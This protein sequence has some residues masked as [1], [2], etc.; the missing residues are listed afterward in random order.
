MGLP[1]FSLAPVPD[2]RSEVPLQL[3]P[4]FSVRPGPSW[5]SCLRLPLQLTFAFDAVESHMRPSSCSSA[6]SS[7]DHA[8]CNTAVVVWP[9]LGLACRLF[10]NCP[11]VMVMFFTLQTVFCFPRRISLGT[12]LRQ[13]M[14]WN[15]ISFVETRPAD[16]LVTF[17]CGTTAALRLLLL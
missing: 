12:L 7:D 2:S 5:D 9:Q 11:A 1:A 13:G 4:F 17:N 14:S 8:R 15:V 6:A 10:L 16:E 3:L